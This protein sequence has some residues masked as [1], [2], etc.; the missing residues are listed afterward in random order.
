MQ[1]SRLILLDDHQI[2]IDGLTPMLASIEGVVVVASF[3]D[4]R[5][6]LQ[7]LEQNVNIDILISDLHIP[8]LS[9]IDLTLQIRKFF[10]HVK[11][12][13]LT[14]AD[15]G[16]HIR[17]AIKAGVH[18]YLLKNATK[19]D[20]KNAFEALK[21]GRRFYSQEVVEELVHIQDSH[22]SVVQ[23]VIKHLTLREIEILKLVAEEYSTTQIADKLFVAVATIETHRRNLMEKLGAKNVVGLV[24]YAIKHGLVD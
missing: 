24:K 22:D 3:T 23:D 16:V 9:G 14:M 10:P 8:Y 7:F 1:H 15:D 20:F 13:L 11:V 4:S 6:V 17:E 12:L 2:L 19:D 18:G 21:N 5:K